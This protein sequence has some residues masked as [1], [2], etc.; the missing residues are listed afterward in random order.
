M[1]PIQLSLKN[2]LSYREAAPNL[3]LEDVHVACLCGPNGNGKSALL[4]AITWVLW[5]RARGQRTDQLLHH[6]QNEMSVDLIF[7]ISNNRYR[8]SRRYSKARST[9][10]SSLELYLKNTDGN[11]APITGDS[12]TATQ[13]FIIRLINMDYDTFV[14]SAFLVQGR[15]DAFTMSSPTQRK[16]V[17][18]K[19]L[20]L[21][22]YDRLEDRAKMHARDLQGHLSTSN[23]ISLRLEEQISNYDAK[24]IALSSVGNQLAKSNDLEAHLLLKLGTINSTIIELEQLRSYQ[25]D[26][27]ESE[28]RYSRRK[29]EFD[30]ELLNLESKIN[31]HY[32]IQASSEPI[33]Q[34]YAALQDEKAIL[35]SLNITAQ[36]ALAFQVELAPLEKI[37]NESRVSLEAKIASIQQTMQN[38]LQPKIDSRN[39][40]ESQYSSVGIEIEK[41]KSQLLE[42]AED[43]KKNNE[44]YK[45]IEALKHAKNNL[46]TEGNAT[47]EK[48]QILQ[49]AHT[50]Q[51]SCPLCETLLT[52]DG[53]ERL[54]KTY[55]QTIESQRSLYKEK[56]ELIESE[57]S[58]YTRLE[59]QYNDSNAS[60][61]SAIIDSERTRGELKTLL[62]NSLK[63]F[64]MYEKL[65]AELSGFEINLK[66]CNY[67]PREQV[68]C[69]KIRAQLNELNYDPQ[70][71][72]LSKDKISKLLIWEESHQKLLLANSRL[73]EDLELQISLKA[74][75]QDNE[76]DL[77]RNTTEL[78]SIREK[79]KELSPLNIEKAA[80][81]NSLQIAQ[82]EKNKLLNE[83]GSLLQELKEI[84]KAKLELSALENERKNL[85][86][87][88]SIYTELAITFG[89]G[90]VQA[91]LIEAAIPRLE[92]EAN[93]LLHRMSDGKMS[94]RLETQKQRKSAS[95]SSDVA[96]TLEII[97]ADELGTRSY[98]MF[99]GGERFRV[100]FAIRIALSKLL[101]WRSGAPLPTLFIDEGFGTQDT[102]GRDRII[103]VLKAIEDQFECILVITHLDSIKEAFPL[104]IEVRRTAEGS[105]F[106]VY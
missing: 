1:L 106:S 21:G 16:E 103:E 13:S 46:Y 91:L 37:I 34:G 105:T 63:A 61:T 72:E 41:L 8:V 93:E 26:R 99:S 47:K 14:N 78:V 69:E 60:I 18:T 7:D 101:A 80:L 92:D 77:A 64:E 88:S 97:V 86:F 32:E 51:H 24:K 95:T 70:L 48:L 44:R 59:K 58:I 62:D 28:Q 100:D 11:Y 36:K 10:Q 79:V 42:L 6:G 27:E 89:K 53:I 23:S 54:Q 38:E 2:F 67:A 39:S 19:V 76:D 57:E 43:H 104:R 102:D 81:D 15:A 22:L 84:E 31:E 3:V 40:L 5:G 75:I 55:N 50:S 56:S 85:A 49:H 9:P 20:G 65:R 25:I 12:I 82:S 83:E 52:A 17:L 98:E 30:T 71:I 94:I 96:E 4:D 35:N 29:K 87:Q 68:E 90:G 66:E 73:N 45:K 33:L 74:R